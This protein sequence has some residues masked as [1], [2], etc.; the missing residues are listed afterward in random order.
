MVEAANTSETSVT[1]YE[2]TQRNIPEDCHLLLS[3]CY[4]RTDRQTARHSKSNSHNQAIHLLTT[5]AT[6]NYF[7]DST[8]QS[9]VTVVY[10]L[11]KDILLGEGVER[12]G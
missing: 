1:F 10:I 6:G 11:A 9:I 3:I 5:C 2:T 8:F 4:M 7:F 12:E